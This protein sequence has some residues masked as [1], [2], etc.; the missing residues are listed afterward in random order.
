MLPVNAPAAVAV[1]CAVLVGSAMVGS[2]DVP[3]TTP[4]SVG[5]GEPSD[6]ILPLPVAVAEVMAVTACVV[7]V[8]AVPEDAH[9]A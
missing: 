6:V 3:H 9:F 2:A 8:G 1:P 5:L 7:T 4:Y